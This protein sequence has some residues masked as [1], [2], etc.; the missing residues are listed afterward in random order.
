MFGVAQQLLDILQG[1]TLAELVGG[2]GMAQRVGRHVRGDAD[3]FHI[4]F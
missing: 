2:K 1:F 4:M 3:F